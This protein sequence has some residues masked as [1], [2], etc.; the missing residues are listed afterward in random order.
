MKTQAS[1]ETPILV[2][3]GKAVAT[4]DGEVV[5][6]GERA[7]EEGAN[8]KTLQDIETMALLDPRCDWRVV[9][10]GPMDGETFQ[11]QGVGIWLRIEWNAGFA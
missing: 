10:H 9:L 3:F 8:V 11:R 4:K 5:Y 7:Y 6:D 1:M 2:G